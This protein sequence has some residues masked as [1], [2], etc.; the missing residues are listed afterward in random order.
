MRWFKMQNLKF[1][2]LNLS[3][4]QC[5]GRFV[6]QKLKIRGECISC[7]PSDVI[8]Q[9]MCISLPE[10]LDVYSVKDTW[11]YSMPITTAETALK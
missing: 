5:S 10:G 4:L 6:P 8:F 11:K 1:R 9:N 3:W 7:A 2:C